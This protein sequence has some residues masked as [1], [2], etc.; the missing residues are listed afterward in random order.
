MAL[1]GMLR[2]PET[3]AHHIAPGND[4]R[5]VAARQSRE[6]LEKFNIDINDPANGV[7][8]PRTTTSTAPG[9][10]HPTLHTRIYYEELFRR[11]AQA[12]TRDQV[13]Q[14]LNQVRQELLNNTFPH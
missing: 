7:Y 10:Y 5:F 8:L 9:A 3:A 4:S 13:I 12:T 2:P 6:I 11:L 14:I 1:S